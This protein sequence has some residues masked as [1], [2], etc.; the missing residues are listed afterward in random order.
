MK[1]DK[2]KGYIDRRTFL[3]KMGS[4]ALGAVIGTSFVT[5]SMYSLPYITENDKYP[6]NLE[7]K[8]FQLKRDIQITDAEIT[9]IKNKINSLY[10]VRTKKIIDDIIKLKSEIEY[11]SRLL[12]Y[13]KDTLI[14]IQIFRKYTEK[15]INNEIIVKNN[16]PKIN[17]VE[18]SRAEMALFDSCKDISAKKTELEILYKRMRK[19]E[20]VWYEIENVE[21]ELE[22][23]EKT[24]WDVGDRLVTLRATRDLSDGINIL[25]IFNCD[26]YGPFL[27]NG[28]W[29][30][31]DFRRGK[32][33]VGMYSSNTP[34]KN[35]FIDEYCTDTFTT[36]MYYYWNEAKNRNPNTN[37]IQVKWIY[38]ATC[39]YDNK[40]H[41]LIWEGNKNSNSVWY[42]YAQYV[43][44]DPPKGDYGVQCYQNSG[45]CQRYL[46]CCRSPILYHWCNTHCGYCFACDDADATQH[47]VTQNP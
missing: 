19:G 42:T 29:N 46:V 35:Y 21:K 9:A 20:D 18:I 10:K 36:N 43:Y 5:K 3:K 25:G 47:F 37:S 32:V 38:T 40:V 26:P 22:S 14:S 1:E 16:I 34:D 33:W 6:E 4:T 31:S 44:E 41:D 7:K 45:I 24:G 28:I 17:N 11:K 23:A 30:F 12:A 13:K 2:I 39:N 27:P 8:M 15:G